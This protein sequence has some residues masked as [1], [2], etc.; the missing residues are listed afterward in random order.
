MDGERTLASDLLACV[1]LFVPPL[2]CFGVVAIIGALV[3]VSLTRS[4]GVAVI[5]RATERERK[6]S[7][8]LQ[9]RNRLDEADYRGQ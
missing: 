4:L 1:L 8:R 3:S 6:A 7:K 5:D 2:G 9:K